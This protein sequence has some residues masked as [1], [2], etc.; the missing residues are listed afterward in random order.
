[1]RRNCSLPVPRGA[2]KQEGDQFFTQ[3]D[4]DKTGE[5]SFKVEEDRLKLDVRKKFL[6]TRIHRGW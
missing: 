2:Y 3:S 6:G 4:R 1:M 5:N